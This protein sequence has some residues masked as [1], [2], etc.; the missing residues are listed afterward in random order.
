MKGINLLTAHRKEKKT[1]QP[2]WNKGE[3][4]EKEIGGRF[5][6]PE[7]IDM[8]RY[9]K[10][11]SLPWCLSQERTSLRVQTIKAKSSQAPR[12]SEKRVDKR[13]QCK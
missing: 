12:H 11:E 3:M 9:Q 13:Y 7:I 8:K 2:S 4:A 10:D 1:T 5:L 6:S